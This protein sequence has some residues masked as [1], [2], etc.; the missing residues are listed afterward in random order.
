MG[1]VGVDQPAPGPMILDFGHMQGNTVQ[2]IVDHWV[3][4]G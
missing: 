1:Q 2:I 4:V 3:N